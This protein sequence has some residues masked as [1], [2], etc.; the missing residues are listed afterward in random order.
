MHLLAD[1]SPFVQNFL[2][3]GAAVWAL[4]NIED[5]DRAFSPSIVFPCTDVAVASNGRGTVSVI[6]TGDRGPDP[7]PWTVSHIINV[8]SDDSFTP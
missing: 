2:S 4:E 6:R 5:C 1:A 8:I 7:N 3:E